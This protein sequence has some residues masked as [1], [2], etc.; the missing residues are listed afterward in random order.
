MTRLPHGYQPGLDR[1][2]G[3][4]WLPSATGLNENGLGPAW[5]C[6]VG[7]AGASLA[8]ITGGQ[9]NQFRR[10]VVPCSAINQPLGPRLNDATARVYKSTGGGSGGFYFSATFSL[11]AWTAGS[12]LF[13]GLCN[14]T[15]GIVCASDLAGQAGE[16]TG[17]YRDT[18][19]TGNTLSLLV[20]GTSASTKIAPSDTFN[21]GPNW[22]TGQGF[23]FEMWAFPH[24]LKC[25]ARLCSLNTLNTT[26]PPNPPNPPNPEAMVLSFDSFDGPNANTMLQPQVQL[27]SAGNAAGV[28]LGV[29]NILLQPR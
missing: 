9:V 16:I 24:S 13:V 21:G 18:A 2:Y 26:P 20:K 22:V 14:T 7:G 5:L 27:N 23:R 4:L 8:T 19:D 15:A 25:F 28:S 11:E 1:F 12:R 29:M 6:D 3:S 10:T 17:L